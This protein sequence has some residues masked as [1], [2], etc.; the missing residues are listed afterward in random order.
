MAVVLTIISGTHRT[1]PFITTFRTSSDLNYLATLHKY[2]DICTHKTH[3]KKPTYV[4]PSDSDTLFQTKKTVPVEQGLEVWI[5]SC[6]NHR[7]LLSQTSR[8]PWWGASLC[9]SCI[10]NW[11][12]QRMQWDYWDSSGVFVCLFLFQIWRG[13]HVIRVMT[14]Y[15]MHVLTAIVVKRMLSFK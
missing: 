8:L 15:W 3:S 2:T 6:K 7:T 14:Q 12:S 13:F 4:T 5:G 10:I 1:H 11:R 9:L